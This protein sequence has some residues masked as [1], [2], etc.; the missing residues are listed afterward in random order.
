MPRGG[1][2]RT[3][4]TALGNLAEERE[5]PTADRRFLRRRTNGGLDS[6][7]TIR[8]AQRAADE[9]NSGGKVLKTRGPFLLKTDTGRKTRTRMNQN[10]SIL[11]ARGGQFLLSHD[12]ARVVGAPQAPPSV[13]YPTY[14][15]DVV[16]STR[17]VAVL[18]FIIAALQSL[19]TLW[20]WWS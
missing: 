3:V 20:R 11:V 16:I 7:D 6:V 19:E 14:E 9:R 2:Q 1:N 4:C 12:S 18:R 13:P 5:I 8:D 10:G 15:G 17:A